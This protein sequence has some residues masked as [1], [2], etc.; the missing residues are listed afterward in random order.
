M[1]SRGASRLAGVCWGIHPLKSSPLDGSS[2]L[3]TLKARPEVPR[4]LRV[5]CRFARHCPPRAVAEPSPQ[6]F[7]GEK[8]PTV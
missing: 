3:S 8:L 2:L 4:C 7:R 6:H 5:P 1:S